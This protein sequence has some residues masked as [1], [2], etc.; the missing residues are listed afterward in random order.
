MCV[1]LLLVIGKH[2]G[3]AISQGKVIPGKVKPFPTLVRPDCADARP[4]FLTVFVFARVPAMVEDIRWR[5]WHRYM[6]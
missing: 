4:D 2:H 1:L 3:E 6:S 5:V